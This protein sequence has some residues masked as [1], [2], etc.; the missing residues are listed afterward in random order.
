MECNCG[1]EDLINGSFKSG[2]FVSNFLILH[3]EEAVE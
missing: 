3:I 1:E 2:I